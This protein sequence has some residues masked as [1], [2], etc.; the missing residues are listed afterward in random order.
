MKIVHIEPLFLHQLP[1]T[2]YV[3]ERLLAA[4]QAIK[5][6][7]D[8]KAEADMVL[9]RQDKV[10]A[11]EQDILVYLI[12][13]GGKTPDHI[14]VPRQSPCHNFD[15]QCTIYYAEPNNLKYYQMVISD[16][17]EKANTL[18][19][20]IAIY[21]NILI[22]HPFIDYNGKY[23]RSMLQLL[24]ARH[25]AFPWALTKLSLSFAQF[26]LQPLLKNAYLQYYET[27][28]YRTLSESLQKALI[29]PAIA[30]L[31]ILKGE[32]NAKH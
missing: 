14:L 7:S 28:D 22:A 1:E 27:G 23:A 25:F 5:A 29:E 6:L 26:D 17:I 20:Y 19:H 16:Q 9:P 10:S 30:I 13:N 18:D 15:E 2:P 11:L 3:N 8:Q 32:I 21:K 4:F 12:Q 24:I 31:D